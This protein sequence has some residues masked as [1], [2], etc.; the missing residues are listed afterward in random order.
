MAFL[1]DHEQKRPKNALG[2]GI[3]DFPGGVVK[4]VEDT[5]DKWIAAE[6]D[7]RTRLF[8]NLKAFYDIDGGAWPDAD[9]ADLRSQGRHPAS[10]NIAEQKL[11]TLAGSIQACLL[12][13]SPSPRD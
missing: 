6:Q 11:Y 12:Y 1:V 3:K 4:F 10:Y 8:E 13:T 7:N 5:N 2:N 9:L